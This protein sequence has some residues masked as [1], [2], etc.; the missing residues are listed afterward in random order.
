MSHPPE[1]HLTFLGDVMLGRLIDQLLPHPLPP[2]PSTL[3]I[4]TAITRSP[5]LTPYPLT[6]PF[7]T[8]LPLLLSSALLLLNLETA[9]TTHPVPWPSKTFAY[10]THPAHIAALAAAHVDYAGLANNHVLDFREPGL[11]ETIAAVEGTGISYAG[12]RQSVEEEWT[13][14]V[15]RVP[16]EEGSEGG[17]GPF[18]VHVWAATDHPSEWEDTGLVHMIDYTA[19]TRARL[20]A[21]LTAPRADA[22][23]PDL[24]VFSVHWGPNYRWTP[25]AE[26]RGL[27][28]FLIDECGVDVVH[29]HSSHHVQG[30]K[31]YK[32]RL[33]LFGCGD[34][35]D[36]YAVDGGWRNDLGAVWRVVVE[37]SKEDK[38]REGRGKG[39]VVKKLEVFPTAI[40]RFRA[41]R[42]GPE[43]ADH[44]WVTEKI[45]G[46]SG[47]LGTTVEEGTG[48][49]GQLVVNVNEA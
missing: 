37:G 35:V 3:P 36:D 27:A 25:A 44:E 6:A 39:L 4:S 1:F 32:R 28:R 22:P 40:R 2:S 12:A 31:V 42:L 8:T 16:R 29:G 17:D 5:S 23:P 15:L 43:E 45:R 46:L 7:S 41:E 9:A 21:L 19:A 26:V 49:E 34:F 38:G 47:E 13:P 30:V 10:R 33:V 11:R 18:F 24:V 48:E 20:K 14:A